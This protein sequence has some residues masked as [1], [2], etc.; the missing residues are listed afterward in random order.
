MNTEQFLAANA[1][2]LDY[3][4][5]L[6]RHA[7]RKWRERDLSGTRGMVWHQSLGARDV[8]SNAKYHVEPNH[9]SPEGL[10]GL[11]YTFFIEPSG[12]TYLCNDL[13]HVTY[14]QGDRTK[15]GDEN[16]LYVAVCFGGN[17]SGQGH[18][19][20]DRVTVGQ[21]YAG[22]RLWL[23]MQE[24]YGWPETGLYG[25]YHFGKP[26]CPGTKLSQIVEW[27]REAADEEEPRYILFLPCFF[28]CHFLSCLNF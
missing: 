20:K 6:P 27:I 12:D 14:S 22:I 19:G 18:E 8:A 10:P 17:F 15:P 16:Q 7:T 1:W 23:I 25:H 11:S 4:D 2:V 24:G 5:V 13:E 9:I 26:A 3:R 21:I 28:L